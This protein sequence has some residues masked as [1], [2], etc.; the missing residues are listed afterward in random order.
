VLFRKLVR[1][2]RSAV[3]GFSSSNLPQF[4]AAI[5]YRVLLSLF[6]LALLVASVVGLLLRDD[7]RRAEVAADITDRIPLL[8]DAGVD[9]DAALS[10]SLTSL[11]VL[12]G[13]GL[14]ALLWASSG[15][16]AALRVGLNAAWRVEK[17]QAY[18]RG[19]LIDLLLV[20]A[21]NVV[22]VASVGLTLVTPLFDLPLDT[23]LAASFAA[24]TS[25]WF[26]G[27]AALYRL[28]PAVRPS[29]R[30]AVVGSSL[31][32]LGLVVLEEGF[33]VYASRFADY[34]AVYGSLATVVAFLIF[35]YLS[36][37]VV[38]L[39]AAVAAAWSEAEDPTAMAGQVAGE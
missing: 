13:I 32:A 28:V 34:D 22:V 29:G 10:T 6:P 38:L 14:V 15:M 26:V 19:K 37:S 1:T 12:G 9:L 20:T 36:A 25:A 3:R 5:A 30:E 4:A 17:R 11:G 35:V 27:L 21:V 31:A 7:D 2:S 33:S 24:R 8:E 16:M 39:G 18:V 23:S